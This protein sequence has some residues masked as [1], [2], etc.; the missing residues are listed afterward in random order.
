MGNL[1]FLRISI[2]ELYFIHIKGPKTAKKK[3]VSYTL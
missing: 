1:F 2:L 3:F